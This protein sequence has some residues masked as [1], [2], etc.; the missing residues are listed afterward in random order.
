MKKI[1]IILLLTSFITFVYSQ[2]NIYFVYLSKKEI[3]SIN[4][5]ITLIR[6][7]YNENNFN[8][9]YIININW[10]VEKKLLKFTIPIDP[11]EVNQTLTRSEFA[12]LICKVFN[13]KGGLVNTKFLTKY[14]AFNKC[15]KI[16]VLSHGRG[17]LD[18]FT[19]A[20]LIDTFNYLEYYINKN[21][22]N[23]NS[24]ELKFESTYDFLPKWKKNFYIELDEE[25]AKLKEIRIKRK[26]EREKNRIERAKQIQNKIKKQTEKF[27]DKE[28]L[29]EPK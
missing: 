4:D 26:E 5:G 29:T 6:L 21:K 13:I 10:A 15:K 25:R 24:D 17:Q 2:E 27:I 23:I 3:A 11:D 8:A 12:Y 19:G 28:D 22:I 14:H 20:E 7:L 9:S 1:I 18:T 16:G